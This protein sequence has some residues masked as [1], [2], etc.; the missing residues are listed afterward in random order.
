LVQGATACN[1]LGL[2]AKAYER[3]FLNQGLKWSGFF[4]KP[5]LSL[6]PSITFQQAIMITANVPSAKKIVVHG[7]E[8]STIGVPTQFPIQEETQFQQLLSD[9][10]EFFN[11]ADEEIDH[12]FLVDL[13]TGMLHNPSAYGESCKRAMRLEM[14]LVVVRDFYFFHR[15]FYP[16]LMLMRLEDA[17]AAQ[18]KLRHH[19]F[20][21]VGGELYFHIFKNY[22]HYPLNETP[23]AHC[24]SR[25]RSGRC[26]SRTKP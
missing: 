7:P 11:I 21:Q 2:A 8:S 26:C 20:L 18:R 3:G 19:A 10:L 17:E 6:I 9:A 5:K 22:Y 24:R 23:S 4:K 12:H 13:K 15:S 14:S 25:S 1:L 16:Q